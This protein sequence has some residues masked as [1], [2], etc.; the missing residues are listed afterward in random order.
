M[1]V[2][3]EK[4]LQEY[5]DGRLSESERS[6]FELRLKADAQL[7]RKA[8]A[9]LE[10]RKNLREDAAELPPGFYARARERFEQTGPGR[11]RRWFRLLSWESAGL[12]AAV[13]LV[14]VLF[15]PPLMQD[16]SFRDGV[17][18]PDRRMS[19]PS[20][21]RAAADSPVASAEE[22]KPESKS[23]AEREPRRESN[24][25]AA[26]AETEGQQR[27]LELGDDSEE[28]RMREQVEKE[29]VEKDEF[30]VGRAVAGDDELRDARDDVGAARSPAPQKVER[31][32]E[33]RAVRVQP[34]L[35]LRQGAGRS[36]TAPK[37]KKR[38]APETVARENEYEQARGDVDHD[39]AVGGAES[40][41]AKAPAD[42]E[43][44]GY[45]T[46]SEYSPDPSTP[47]SGA[48]PMLEARELPPGAI[49]TGTVRVVATEQEWDDAVPHASI[50]AFESPTF[51]P[52]R[53][54]VLIGPRSVSFACS[55][56]TARVTRDRTEILLPH[57]ETADQT[58]GG[59]C[60]VY[61]PRSAPAGVVVR[62]PS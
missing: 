44:S 36:A 23:D 25:A 31:E 32:S 28:L 15:V 42:P 33:P 55:P 18:E 59:G 22:A 49:P 39:E 50:S 61:L 43:A 38:S 56:I 21:R 12:A 60:V 57:P 52:G 1:N 9:A 29:A 19:A 27:R 13:A 30:G 46:T 11:G 10:L 7:Q 20:P 14:A 58:A 2:D 40:T 48:T 26:T 5:L 37:E 3:D 35:D 16:R 4:R 24:L 34:T 62:D 54:V 47:G 53:R 17:F 51:E 6:A 8:R 45:I 41:G